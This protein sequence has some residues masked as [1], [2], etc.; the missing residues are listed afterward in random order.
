MKAVPFHVDDP[1]GG[2]VLR[3]GSARKRD[4]DQGSKE[5]PDAATAPAQPAQDQ[6]APPKPAAPAAWSCK[7]CWAASPDAVGAVRLPVSCTRLAAMLEAAC[8]DVEGGAKACVVV[9]Q[10]EWMVVF[11]AQDRKEGGHGR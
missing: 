4:L 5:L 2:D 7:A 8:A 6:P 3:I 1:A 11:K 9:Q 10:G